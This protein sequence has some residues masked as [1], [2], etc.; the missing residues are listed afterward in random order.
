M[1]SYPCGS[2]DQPPSSRGRDK[3]LEGLVKNALARLVGDARPHPTEEG[4]HE[5]WAKV[6]GKRAAKHS[7]P[8]S[9][10]RARLI[11]NVDQSSWLYELTI[12]KKEI[13]RRLNGQFV[14]RRVKDLQFRIGEV[15]GYQSK[16]K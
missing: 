2:P 9:L 7:C 5:A 10:R 14:G 16:A 6:A 13:L 4:A 3:P 11:I 1:W 12:K 8:A 15:K